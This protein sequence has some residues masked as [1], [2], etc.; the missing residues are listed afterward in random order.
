MYSY[1]TAYVADEHRKQLIDEAAKHRLARALRSTSENQ[2]S[3]S[4][5]PL[6][7]RLVRVLFA[8]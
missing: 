4:E 2:V 6:A 7:V 8:H 1:L 5:R 3:G